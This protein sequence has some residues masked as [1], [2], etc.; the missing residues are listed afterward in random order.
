[1]IYLQVSI[2]GASIIFVTRSQRWSFLERPG[3]LLCCAFVL[4]QTAA[5]FIGVYGF[6][7]YQDFKGCGWAWALFVWIYSV[8]VYLPLDPIKMAMGAFAQRNPALFELKW[9]PTIRNPLRRRK[10]SANKKKHVE[11]V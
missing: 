7:G 1:M 11:E 4:S 3:F 9:L 6:N 8:I 5:T 10:R 2:T